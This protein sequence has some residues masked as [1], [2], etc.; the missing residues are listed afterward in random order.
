MKER[1]GIVIDS[2][3]NGILNGSLVESDVEI[4]LN[5]N[6]QI[7][8]KPDIFKSRFTYDTATGI[9]KVNTFTLGWEESKRIGFELKK[10][11]FD[12]VKLMYEG[13]VYIILGENQVERE[14]KQ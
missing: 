13:D 11:G 5:L 8:V 2:W 6:S 4:K 10:I 1:I 3:R 12:N 14:K 9:Y 7:E